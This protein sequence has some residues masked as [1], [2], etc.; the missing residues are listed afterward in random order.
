MPKVSFD[1][2]K[3]DAEL[4][5]SARP[6]YSVPDAAG[7]LGIPVSTIRSW[8]FGITYGAKGE[9]EVFSPVLVTS[10]PVGKL[11]S[12]DNLIEAFVLRQFRVK[13]R[14]NLRRVHHALVVAREKF[15][16]SRPLLDP[17]LLTNGRSLFLEKAGEVIGL[18]DPNQLLL[19]E[20]RFFFDRIEYRDS[21][22]DSLFPL[23]RE[24]A[25]E[26][27]RIVSIS[28]SFAFG[29]AAVNR[30]K[31]C[32]SAIHSRYVSGESINDL[33]DDYSCE[34]EEIEESIRAEWIFAHGK[35]A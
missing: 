23:T 22:I 9:T 2:D 12:F 17:N 24:V 5:P 21:A 10:D 25:S 26:S 15:H 11:L 4:P 18:E 1:I 29:R 16:I 27:P 31:V 28:P 8:F 20:S 3:F 6:A 32:T 7:Y 19:P 34:I 33:A 13:D 30:T 35:A 14:M